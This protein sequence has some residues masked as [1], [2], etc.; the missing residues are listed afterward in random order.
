M[1]AELLTTLGEPK[2]L[3]I[4]EA[5]VSEPK[6]VSEL[7]ETL[8]TSQPTVSKHLRVL[9]EA[10]V[11]SCEVVAQRRIYQL[12]REPF[13]QLDAWL[14]RYRALW[15]GHLDALENFLDTEDQQHAT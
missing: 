14:Q 4:V 13:Q 3:Q 11:V 2:R 8:H 1:T 6:S 5:L 12:R 15:E 10:G 7:V 9:R